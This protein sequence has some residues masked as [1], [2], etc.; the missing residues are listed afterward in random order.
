M[1][2]H[3]PLELH[4]QNKLKIAVLVGW[5]HIVH[6]IEERIDHK[7]N[8]HIVGELNPSAINA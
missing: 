6:T 1:K 5:A 2:W 7:R 4:R 3:F 8:D